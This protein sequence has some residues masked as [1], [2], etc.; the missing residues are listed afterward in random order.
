MGESEPDPRFTLANERTFLAWI[1]TA[2]ALIGGG[3][4]A[5]QLLVGRSRAQEL[6]ISLVPIAL[7]AWI[8]VM[9]H[10]RW[11]R[12]QRALR[13]GEPLPADAPRFLPLIIVAMAIVIAAIVVLD[14]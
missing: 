10:Q 3:L 14:A 7:G 9:A 11:E 8:A 4:A 2:L 13:A 12:N 6:I 1:R 5:S